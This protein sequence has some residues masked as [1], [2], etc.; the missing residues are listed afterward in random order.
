MNNS[1]LT[2]RGES[3]TSLLFRT[4][5]AHQ[6]AVTS[7]GS[8]TSRG[9]LSVQREEREEIQCQAT[10]VRLLSITEAFCADRLLAEVER[11][12]DR[13]PHQSLRAVWE[14]SAILATNSWADQQAA[15][16]EYLGV[17]LEN[18]D[19][20]SIERLAEARNAVAHGLGKLTRRQ[21]RNRQSVVA[22]LNVCG[23]DVE[24][25]RILLSGNV[26]LQAAQTCSQFVH[27]LDG[28]IEARPQAYR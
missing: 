25:G 13:V 3:A 15:Y 23:I 18:N 12:V 11:I 8:Q 17:S 19:W 2:E 28:A 9:R 24:D 4:I 6:A 5:A 14:R 21:Q 26:L 16:K 20:K 7:F 1:V 27:K 22:R 10:L